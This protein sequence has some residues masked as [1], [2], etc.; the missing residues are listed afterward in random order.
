MKNLSFAVIP[1]PPPTCLRGQAP[2]GIRWL[3]E[4]R[5]PRLRGHY[6]R[7]ASLRDDGKWVS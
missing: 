1:A 6:R 7:R 4:L 2:A 3:Q 5:D